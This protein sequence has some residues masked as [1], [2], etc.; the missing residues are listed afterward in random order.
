[1][2]NL[3]FSNP[4][5]NVTLAQVYDSTIGKLP[6]YDTASKVVVKFLQENA[7][8]K[9]TTEKVYNYTLGPVVANPRISAGVVAA[10]V[11]TAGALY[12]LGSNSDT[13]QVTEDAKFAAKLQELENEIAILEAAESTKT[14]VTAPVS[15]EVAV[16]TVASTVTAPVKA[17]SMLARIASTASAVF[18]TI[19]QTITSGLKFLFASIASLFVRNNTSV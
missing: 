17:P 11:L 3:Q 14:A 8:T 6:S 12:A 18:A 10:T 2:N 9:E 4:L 16:E 1:M 7:P 5:A 19:A 15:T 13:V